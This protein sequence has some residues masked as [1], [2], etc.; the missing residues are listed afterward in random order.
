MC[1]QTHSY[2][3]TYIHACTCVYIYIHISGAP[4][5]DLL[6][7]CNSCSGCELSVGLEASKYQHSW[8]LLVFPTLSVIFATNFMENTGKDD[9]FHDFHDFWNYGLRALK[10]QNTKIHGNYWIYQ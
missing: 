9:S 4:P 2:V 5:I 10:V 6:F 3:H 7:C 1:A 8:K